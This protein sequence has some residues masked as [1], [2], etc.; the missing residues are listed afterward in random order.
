[1]S[2]WLAGIGSAAM[3]ALKAMADNGVGENY[4]RPRPFHKKMPQ[5]RHFSLTFQKLK[6][7]SPTELK[8]PPGAK[9]FRVFIQAGRQF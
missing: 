8:V 5:A 1:M 6:W 2:N 3:G 7:A 9:G 4:P